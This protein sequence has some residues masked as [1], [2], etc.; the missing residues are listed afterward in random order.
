MGKIA[1]WLE[2]SESVIPTKKRRNCSCLSD[3]GKFICQVLAG[4]KPKV[5]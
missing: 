1:D 4:V 3:Q 5:S 2:N